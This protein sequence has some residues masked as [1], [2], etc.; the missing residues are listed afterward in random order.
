MAKSAYSR[1]CATCESA[2]SFS[3]PSFVHLLVM[4]ELDESSR[5]IVQ[6]NDGVHLFMVA[7]RVGRKA[8][9]EDC[10]AEG[11][12]LLVPRAAS[13]LRAKLVLIGKEPLFARVGP[14]VTLE[15]KEGGAESTVESDK[16]MAATVGQDGRQLRRVTRAQSAGWFTGLRPGT[17]RSQTESTDSGT[18][19]IVSPSMVEPRLRLRCRLG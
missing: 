15:A 9:L 7:L 11:T 16:L 6:R 4:T 10:L 14:T 3:A 17:V 12:E 8:L 19:V 2:D 5:V 1:R 18:I 13:L